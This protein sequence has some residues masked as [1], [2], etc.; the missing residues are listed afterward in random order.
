MIA[1]DALQGHWQRN[2]LRGP[3]FKDS[4]TRV[5]WVQ[6]GQWCA[7]IRI[8]LARPDLAGAGS[9]SALSGADLAVLL[10]AEG[11]AG[12]VVLAEDI[13]TWQR[14]WNWR[15]FPCPVDAG[16]L[17]FDD[18]GHLIEDGV[19][20]EYRED[21]QHAP[22]WPWT[23]SAVQTD[24][25]DGMLVSSETSFVLALGHRGSAALTSLRQ[26]LDDGDAVPADA[27]PAF[28]SVYVMGHWDG[29][30]GIAELSTQPFCEGM[31][32]LTCHE[33]HIRLTMPDFRGAHITR[34]LRL[35]AL[36]T[37]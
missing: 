1:L 29:G 30:Q 2:S 10:S 37:E 28:A 33:N 21:W 15:G 18:S 17:W 19:H 4:T 31:S 35:S 16:K 12:R 32:V 3:G 14:T 8:P 20:A 34:D 22:G 24:G 11:F 26:A 6:A 25:A 23:A 9:L 27:E 7:D 5:H 13:C 36:S